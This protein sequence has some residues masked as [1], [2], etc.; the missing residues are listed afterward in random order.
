M[1]GFEPVEAEIRRLIATVNP[2][3]FIVDISL[4][5]GSHNV[6]SI[7]IDTDQGIR[8]D[9]CARIS[10]YLNREYFE[11][12]DPFDFGFNLEV[13]SPGVGKPLKV[14]RQY[15]KNIGRKLKVKMLDNEVVKGR[16]E[17]VEEDHFVIRPPKSKK[18]KRKE[19]AEAQA[20]T[21][22]IKFDEIKEAT[23]EISFD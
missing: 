21:L 3:V 2:D 12:E 22:E 8:I 1:Q 4:H 19:E 11:V 10:R 9:E 14:R 18:K 17:A 7:L 23:V 15:H 6:L 16:L 20:E 13:S 5:R